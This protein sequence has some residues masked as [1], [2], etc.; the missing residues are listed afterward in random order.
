MAGAPFP[1][2][3]L[4][5]APVL[6]FV[7]G[8]TRRGQKKKEGLFPATKNI[9]LDCRAVGLGASLT[10]LT[11]AFRTDLDPFLGL[12]PEQPSCAMLPIGWP[13]VQYRKPVRRSIDD[14]LHFEKFPAETGGKKPPSAPP[15]EK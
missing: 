7:A 5:E 4:P 3:K 6:L 1:A 11:Q 12:P 2:A 14:C 13:R 15:E 10:P 9:L 8:G